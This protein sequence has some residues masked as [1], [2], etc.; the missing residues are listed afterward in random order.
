MSIPPSTLLNSR[1]R[2]IIT[3]LTHNHEL[4]QNF[5]STSTLFQERNLR[6]RGER[7]VH[8]YTR[9]MQKKERNARISLS[10]TYMYPIY[11]ES[12]LAQALFSF[13]LLSSF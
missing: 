13:L 7:E 2:T 5:R 1:V 6:L 11:Q 8:V 10:L 9:K 4:S 12:G 3:D